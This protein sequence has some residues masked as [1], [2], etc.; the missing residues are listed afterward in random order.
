MRACATPSAPRDAA[1]LISCA[2]C[3]ARFPKMTCIAETSG[4]GDMLYYTP[5]QAAPSPPPSIVRPLTIPTEP[6]GMIRHT[7][8][9]RVTA[10]LTSPCLEAGLNWERLPRRGEVGAPVS[11]PATTDRQRRVV[12]FCH[13]SRVQV[14]A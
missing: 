9:H 2:H 12:C 6:G 13:R 14:I 4:E 10:R 5:C 1:D 7:H 3:C 8:V 11:P